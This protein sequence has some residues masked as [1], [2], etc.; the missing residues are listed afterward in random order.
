VANHTVTGNVEHLT[1]DGDVTFLNVFGKVLHLKVPERDK[2][3]EQVIFYPDNFVSGD[4]D[5]RCPR[6]SSSTVASR[7]TD[8]TLPRDAS[9]LRSLAAGELRS[10]EVVVVRCVDCELIAV[11]LIR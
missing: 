4:G 5:D 3:S 10:V 1:I 2:N 11:D 7:L 9:E 8:V 6:C